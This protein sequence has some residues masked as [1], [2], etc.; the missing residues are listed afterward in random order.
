MVTGAPGEK[1]GCAHS[2]SGCVLQHLTLVHLPGKQESTGSDS[3]GVRDR[4]RGLTHTRGCSLQSQ[5]LMATRIQLRCF[6][7]GTLLG[8]KSWIN[9]RSEIKSDPFGWQVCHARVG[10][11][12]GPGERQGGGP[13]SFLC[14]STCGRAG[15]GPLGTSAPCLGRSQVGGTCVLSWPLPG[16]GWGHTP[17]VPWAI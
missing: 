11:A 3:P 1:P 8:G 14:K 5:G 15:Y 13:D 17:F 16:G 4:G 2:A 9:W 12:G 6:L 7:P 10:P